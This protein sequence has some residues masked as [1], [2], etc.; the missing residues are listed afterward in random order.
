VQAKLGGI[1]KSAWLINFFKRANPAEPL[2]SL[3][4]WQIFKATNF[5]ELN[6]KN[7]A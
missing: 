2:S 6:F 3:P 4:S 7:L 1:Y 5:A